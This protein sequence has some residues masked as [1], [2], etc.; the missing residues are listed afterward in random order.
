VYYAADQPPHQ[1]IEQREHGAS[2]AKVAR[3][4]IAASMLTASTSGGIAASGG[5][6]G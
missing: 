1:H 2:R 4:A 5:C 3:I 6:S